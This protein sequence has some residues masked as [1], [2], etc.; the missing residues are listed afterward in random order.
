METLNQTVHD[1]Q[2]GKTPELSQAMR[3]GPD[4]QCDF[5]TIIPESYIYDVH[6]RLIMYKRIN[7]A[8]NKLALDQLCVEL[9]DR[10]GLLPESTK[11][12]FAITEL[13]LF[14]QTLHI[15]GIQIHKQYVTLDI[16]ETSRIKIDTLIL[17]VQTQPATY[18]MVNANRIRITLKATEA[19]IKIDEVSKILR[20]LAQA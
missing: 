10:F 1:L 18:H 11:H 8:E 4:I 15:A 2:A 12:L 5:S 16:Q 7:H 14:A 17:R 3:H 6:T 20:E 19:L 9:I 13:K